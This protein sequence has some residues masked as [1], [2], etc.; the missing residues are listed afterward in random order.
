MEYRIAMA[1]FPSQVYNDPGATG[2]DKY[3]PFLNRR[4]ISFAEARM[5]E[6]RL[7]DDDPRFG[8]LSRGGSGSFYDDPGSED[9]QA[10]LEPASFGPDSAAETL[11]AGQRIS[12]QDA[13]ILRDAAGNEFYVCF[14]TYVDYDISGYPLELGGRHSVLIL[15]KM[16]L[17]SGGQ[18]SWP[19]FDPAAEFTYVGSY[20]IG[21]GQTSVAY[22]P[23]V[24]AAPCFT[25]GTLIETPTGAR[26]VEDLHPGD[27]V[28]TRDHGMQPLRWIGGTALDGRQLDL[29]PNLCPIL[30]PRDALGPSL[31]ARDLLVSPQHRVLLRSAIAARMFGADQ[32]LVAAKHLTALPG[33]RVLRPAAGVRY[34]HLLFDRHELVHSNGIW[35]ESLL[36]GPQALLALSAAA[37]REIRALLPALPQD[38]ARRLTTGRQGRKLV[39]RHLRHDRAFLPA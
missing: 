27:A 19:Q 25:L 34:L 13:A 26:P 36:T 33:V 5:D 10:L 39:E 6:I 35:T 31:P 18:P 17:D 24:P 38:P 28:L 22:D 9:G 15:P 23:T 20:K 14:P 3:L 11:P 1:T 21:V 32:V 8:Y 4:E 37:R 30:I 29:Q 12:F 7:E 16:R 2:S